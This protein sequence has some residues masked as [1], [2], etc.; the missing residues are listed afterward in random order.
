M[1]TAQRAAPQLPRSAA[2]LAAVQAIYEMEV[3]GADAQSILDNF[4]R[5]RWPWSGAMESLPPPDLDLLTRLV[6]GTQ[7][8]QAHLDTA[9]DAV[10]ESRQGTLRIELLLRA[11]L[12]AGAYEL[13]AMRETPAKVIINEYINLGHAFYSSGEPALV[14]AILDKLA[15]Q[16]RGD[17]PSGS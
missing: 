2:R 11:I 4:L 13:D 14:N 1:K 10:L 3:S 17:R 5:Q 7:E 15:S 12:R 9:I 8:V 6:H 16:F